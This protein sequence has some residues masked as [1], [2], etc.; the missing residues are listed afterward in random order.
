[1]LSLGVRREVYTRVYAE[2]HPVSLLVGASY[3]PDSTIL[4]SYEGIRRL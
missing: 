1:M 3:V 2:H 4:V